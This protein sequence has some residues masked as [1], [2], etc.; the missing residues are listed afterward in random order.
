MYSE[1]SCPICSQSDFLKFGE[2]I[3]YTV[4]RET[5]Q[6]VKCAHCQ[7]LL[8]LENAPIRGEEEPFHPRKQTPAY[9]K[10]KELDFW[11]ALRR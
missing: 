3:D 8:W 9:L 4:S 6:L 10:L 5:F 7:R 11:I 2:A 1:S